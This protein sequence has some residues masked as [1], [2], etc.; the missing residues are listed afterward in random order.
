[1]NVYGRLRRRKDPLLF[2][3]L[4]TMVIVVFPIILI[5]IYIIVFVSPQTKEGTAKSS[6]Q[7]TVNVP[8]TSKV[9]ET[10]PTVSKTTTKATPRNNVAKTTKAIAQLKAQI[11]AL[12]AQ[13]A[14]MQQQLADA[15]GDANGAACNFWRNLTV[16]D[17]GRDVACLQRYLVSL[18]IPYSYRDTEW[19]LGLTVTGYFDQNTKNLVYIWQLFNGISPADGY[20]GMDS[21]ATYSNATGQRVIV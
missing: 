16:G 8:A 18:S 15:Q 14:L 5:V 3:F 4:E 2:A 21:L 6:V 10:S 7:I 11:A 13:I 9:L 20:F 19:P 1:M 17:T 12:L